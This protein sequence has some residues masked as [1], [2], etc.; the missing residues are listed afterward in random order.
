MRICECAGGL[1]VACNAYTLALQHKIRSSSTVGQRRPTSSGPSPSLHGQMTH[2]PPP[3]PHRTRGNDLVGCIGGCPTRRP[4]AGQA[5][6]ASRANG[7]CGPK[8]E[9]QIAAPPRSC[10]VVG[11]LSGCLL[12]VSDGHGDTSAV[13]ATISKLGCYY[14]T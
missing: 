3:P 10:Q 5:A 13:G 8:P 7:P 6:G 12:T 9:F 1:G 11:L 2:R 4:R 14:I